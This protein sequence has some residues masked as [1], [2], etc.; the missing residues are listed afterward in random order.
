MIASLHPV[1]IF[2]TKYNIIDKKY[3]LCVKVGASY[4]QSLIDLLPRT[5]GAMSVKKWTTRN[6]KYYS[7]SSGDVWK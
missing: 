7:S 3:V 1:C 5:D 2:K 4:D 6:P